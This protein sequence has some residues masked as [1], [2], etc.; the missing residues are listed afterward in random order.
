M[1]SQSFMTAGSIFTVSHSCPFLISLPLF[2]PPSLAAVSYPL[3]A[4]FLPFRSSRHGHAVYLHPWKASAAADCLLTAL[5]SGLAVRGGRERKEGPREGDWRI[6]GWWGGGGGE[7]QHRV[8]PYCCWWGGG[9]GCWLWCFIFRICT[10]HQIISLIF[11]F[12]LFSLN[13]SLTLM[14][15]SLYVPCLDIPFLTQPSALI[16]E[17][18]STLP[19][20][21]D[22]FCVTQLN[23]EDGLMWFN[24]PLRPCPHLGDSCFY[25]CAPV[26]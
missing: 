9:G 4:V 3:L 25:W 13:P 1:F 14:S 7:M 10:R 19:Y 18:C 8:D 16:N 26:L 23:A 24:I 11:F 17:P 20:S 22:L 2:Y 6:M 21:A 12:F 5:V 15:W